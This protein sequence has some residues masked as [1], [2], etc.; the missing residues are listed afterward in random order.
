MAVNTKIEA[1]SVDDLLLDPKNPRLGR[2]KVQM[3]LSQDA[4]L[5]EMQNFTL[6]ELAISILQSG[7]WPQEALIA[8]QE[9]PGKLTVVEGNRRL[10]A[11]KWLKKAVSG[12]EVPE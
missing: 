1:K 5:K 4:V 10:A 7:F 2:Q 11:L 12:D 6:D 8:V 3:N 9:K